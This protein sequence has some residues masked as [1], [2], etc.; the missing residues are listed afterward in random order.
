LLAVPIEISDA[1]KRERAR[2][3]IAG[4]VKLS[5]PVQPLVM[6][7]VKVFVI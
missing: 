6:V 5:V 3:R 7:S 4:E 2:V 1:T